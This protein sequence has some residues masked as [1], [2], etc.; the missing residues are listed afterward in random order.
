LSPPVRGQLVPSHL[1]QW[2]LDAPLP[3]R[4]QVQLHKLLWG[5]AKGR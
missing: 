4:F 1:A 5:N 3:L 2:T